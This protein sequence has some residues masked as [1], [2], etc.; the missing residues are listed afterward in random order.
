MQSDEEDGA[1]VQDMLKHASLALAASSSDQLEQV[2]ENALKK[3]EA[4]IRSHDPARSAAIPISS[5]PAAASALPRAAG[6]TVQDVNAADATSLTRC[7]S[8]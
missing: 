5:T 1:A 6:A 4:I 8:R 2:D 7:A 3:P